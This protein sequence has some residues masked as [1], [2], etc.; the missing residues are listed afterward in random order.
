MR[1]LDG[2]NEGWIER[3]GG[4]LGGG[5]GDR[6]RDRDQLGV[7][8]A[9]GFSNIGVV[10]AAHERG[11]QVVG[12]ACTTIRTPIYVDAHRNIESDPDV[13][14]DHGDRDQRIPEDDHHGFGGFAEIAKPSA[15]INCQKAHKTARSLTTLEDPFKILFGLGRRGDA[16]I[17]FLNDTR[18]LHERRNHVL[19]RKVADMLIMVYRKFL[20]HRCYSCCPCGYRSSAATGR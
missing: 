4:S 9:C 15:V 2:F 11:W 8:L 6:F 14:L 13:V 18:H 1:M 16:V 17:A 12:H 7:K 3:N 5:A 19:V 10:E 20:D